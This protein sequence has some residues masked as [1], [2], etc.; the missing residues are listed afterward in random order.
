MSGGSRK[1]ARSS[2]PCRFSRW[3][4]ARWR[5]SSTRWCPISTAANGCG[6]KS[7]R[8]KNKSIDSGAIAARWD[9]IR[10]EFVDFYRPTDASDIEATAA[11]A[12]LA[13]DAAGHLQKFQKQLDEYLKKNVDDI[14]AYFGSLRSL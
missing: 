13:K 7:T 4:R 12:K 6:S 9:Q 1:A 2:R 5:A 14:A 8:S 10:Q 11:Q 3:P